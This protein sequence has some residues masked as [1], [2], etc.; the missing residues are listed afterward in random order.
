MKKLLLILFSIL[1]SFNS[2]GEW[3]KVA[4]STRDDVFY[5][6]L[7]TIKERGGYVNYWELTDLTI[8]LEDTPIFSYKKLVQVDCIEGSRRDKV[9]YY[10]DQSMGEGDIFD[11]DQSPSSKWLYLPPGSSYY[12]LLEYVC[13]FVD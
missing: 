10:Y 8:P 13:D 2:Y 7:A 11:Q 4:E 6:D 5:I 12:A 3:T 9:K 1:I